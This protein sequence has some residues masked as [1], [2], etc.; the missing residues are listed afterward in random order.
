MEWDY[1]YNKKAENILQMYMHFP[2]AAIIAF[3]Q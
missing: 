2:S 1:Y 3:G